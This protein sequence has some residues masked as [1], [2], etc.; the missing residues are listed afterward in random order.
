MILP[1]AEFDSG[2]CVEPFAADNEILVPVLRKFEAR[3]GGLDKLEEIDHLVRR[4]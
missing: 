2:V 3:L 1:A 4:R